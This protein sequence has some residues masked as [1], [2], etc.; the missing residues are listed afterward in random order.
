MLK[1]TLT[2]VCL[3][4]F[5]A[6]PTFADTIYTYYF[7]NNASY[8][9]S[10]GTEN[11]A[12][13]F[14][15]DATTTSLVSVNFTVT[16]PGSGTF[17]SPTSVIYTG[18]NGYNELICVNNTA[19]TLFQQVAFAQSLD[20]GGT[21]PLALTGN[22]GY[23][24][25]QSGSVNVPPYFDALTITGSVSTTATPEPASMVLCGAGLLFAGIVRRRTG[26]WLR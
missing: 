25:Y 26:R 22:G 10:R 18:C 12:G 19:G 15:Y 13:S 24:T 17:Q 20:L 4:G 9:D 11:L 1:F 14:V 8:T 21:D 3:L 6:S 5:A 7:S 2:A 16:G 23:P